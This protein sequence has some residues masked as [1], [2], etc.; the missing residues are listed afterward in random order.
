[1]F[2]ILSGRL[3]NKPCSPCLWFLD[4]SPCLK[5]P[6][7][8]A[9]RRMQT[10]QREWVEESVRCLIPA[11]VLQQHRDQHERNVHAG[12]CEV[13][14]L[15]LNVQQELCLSWQPGEPPEHPETWLSTATSPRVSGTGPGCGSL[16]ATWQKMHQKLAEPWEYCKKIRNKFGFVSRIALPASLVGGSA[17][18]AAPAF[19]FPGWMGSWHPW[20]RH[21]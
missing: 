20:R 3:A 6:P 4:C 16:Q 12:G 21:K 10:I 19:G 9:H 5:T 1:M 15:S 17:G 7:T 13:T 11:L 14:C 18:T 8:V 2:K